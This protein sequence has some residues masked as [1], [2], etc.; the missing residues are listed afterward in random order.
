MITD[1]SG[2]DAWRASYEAFGETIP[3]GALGSFNLRFPGQYYD[4][5]TETAGSGSGLHCNRFRY[6][7]PG[8]G[9]YIS[10]DPIGQGGGVNV[11]QYAHAL[12]TVLADPLGLWDQISI[13]ERGSRNGSTY[14]ATVEVTNATGGSGA[15]SGSSFP[16]P[17]NASPG[18]AAGDFDGNF[19]VLNTNGSQAVRIEDGAPIPTLGPNRNQG[20]QS[21]AD[22]IAIHCGDSPTNR[23][24][25]GCITLSPEDCD[26]FFALFGP[27]ETGPVSLRRPGPPPPLPDPSG[28]NN[29]PSTNHPDRLRPNS[30][31]AAEPRT[32]FNPF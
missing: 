5:E 20:G 18:I 17:T 11:L 16:N 13:T 31:L 23:G 3:S 4:A 6:Y 21:I 28:P 9:R 27:G 8:A 30:L 24:S 19:G 25:A 32:S 29:N 1:A 15:F 12:P 14:G 2:G 7:G 10:A 26:A 22:G